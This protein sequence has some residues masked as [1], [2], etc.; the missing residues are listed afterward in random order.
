MQR[1]LDSRFRSLTRDFKSLNS[2]C[3]L[4]EESL[5]AKYGDEFIDHLIIESKQ[6]FLKYDEFI[7]SL[8]SSSLERKDK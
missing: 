7:N 4:Y 2:F 6:Q 3:T 5:K 1:D 8:D